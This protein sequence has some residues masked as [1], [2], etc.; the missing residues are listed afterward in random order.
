MTG[1]FLLINV[2]VA[3]KP[4]SPTHESGSRIPSH[5]G[6]VV[7]VVIVEVVHAP[8]RAGHFESTCVN[9][10]RSGESLTQLSASDTLPQVAGLPV[11][12]GADVDASHVSHSTGHSCQS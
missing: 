5:V 1:Q 10:H 2:T 6:V 9:E 4:S 8:Q 3:H 7:E 11:V 12:A